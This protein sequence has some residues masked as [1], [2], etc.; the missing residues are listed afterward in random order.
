M[1]FLESTVVMGGHEPVQH[2]A[3]G[4]LPGGPYRHK[5]FQ[6]A[7]AAFVVAFEW[8]C[9]P[10]S[11]VVRCGWQW[12]RRWVMIVVVVVA[13]PFGVVGCVCDSGALGGGV[14]SLLCMWLSVLLHGWWVV[15]R[16]VFLPS[17]C[18]V[19]AQVLSVTS[20]GVGWE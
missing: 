17:V 11:V 19:L 12:S 5:R 10:G 3:F 14:V 7:A 2:V 13:W 8:N 15:L 16:R 20:C 18:E 4:R 6:V 9:V 1:S